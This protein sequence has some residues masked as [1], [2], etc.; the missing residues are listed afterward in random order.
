[1]KTYLKVKI[2]PNCGLVKN[3]IIIILTSKRVAANAEKIKMTQI[4]RESKE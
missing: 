3:V 2:K 1:M 4:N